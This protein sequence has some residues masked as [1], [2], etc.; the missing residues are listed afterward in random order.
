[1]CPVLVPCV[2]R[3]P[4]VSFYRYI[5]TRKRF[6]FFVY[7]LHTMRDAVLIQAVARP[8]PDPYVYKQSRKGAPFFA[9]AGSRPS[10][11]GVL[12]PNVANRIFDQPIVAGAVDRQAE[13]LLQQ[14]KAVISKLRQRASSAKLRQEYA[15]HAHLSSSAE[16]DGPPQRP[17]SA[18]SASRRAGVEWIEAPATNVVAAPS[19][20]P[21]LPS[22]RFETT[23]KSHYPEFR[24]SSDWLRPPRVKPPNNPPPYPLETDESMGRTTS[25]DC[26]HVPPVGFPARAPVCRPSEGEPVWFEPTQSNRTLCSTYCAQYKGFFKVPQQKPVVYPVNPPPYMYVGHEEALRRSTSVDS[27]PRPP[28]SMLQRREPF[29]PPVNPPPYEH[30]GLEPPLSRTTSADA[31]PEAGRYGSMCRK[32]DPIFPPQ[33]R[34]P[35]SS[36]DDLYMD[37]PLTTYKAQFLHMGA[38][39]S[40]AIQVQQPVAGR[41]L[42]DPL[43]TAGGAIFSNDDYY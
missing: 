32:R 6:T 26:F 43:Q 3:L 21:S 22:M 42:V 35:Y 16:P 37:T 17:S 33:N 27:F 39:V 25:Q 18:H 28:R 1:M 23:Y 14:R 5:E 29:V 2:F 15:A 38:D 9:A 8:L 41:T 36:A 10:S 40:A 11:A 4:P 13:W 30:V 20:K 7:A 31:F 19:K 24:G 34:A 12:K